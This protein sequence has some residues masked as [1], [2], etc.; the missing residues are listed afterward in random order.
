[1]RGLREFGEDQSDK[2]FNAL[3]DKFDE[4]AERPLIYQSVDEI[5]AG[6]RRAVCGSESIYYR[7]GPDGVEV[8]A[9]IGRQD[10]A[11]WL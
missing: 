2:Y 1:M 4:I 6:Y 10:T 11:D 9:I 3:F 5:R 8:M 7:I